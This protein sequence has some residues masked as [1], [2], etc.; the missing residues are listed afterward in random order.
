MKALLDHL[1]GTSVT[2][3]VIRLMWITLKLIAVTAFI[4]QSV[5]QFIYAGF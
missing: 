3:T 2:A 5:S 4:S 1:S